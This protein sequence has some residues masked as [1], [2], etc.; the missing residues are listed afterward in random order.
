M[1]KKKNGRKGKNGMRKPKRATTPSH[2]IPKGESNR[3]KKRRQHKEQGDG[4][5]SEKK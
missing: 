4:E 2:Q 1:G 5:K 3:K